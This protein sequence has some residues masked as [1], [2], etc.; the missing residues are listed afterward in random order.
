MDIHVTLDLPPEAA[1]RLKA[2]TPDLSQAVREAFAL[3]LFRRGILDRPG[4]SRVLGLDR[5]ETL[6]LLKRRGIFRGALSHEEVDA[7]VK[8]IN[9]LLGSPRP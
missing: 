4:L 6:A 2:E 1:E 7:D 9:E 8:S 5:F 3:D